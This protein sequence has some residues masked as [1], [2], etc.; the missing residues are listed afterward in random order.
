MLGVVATEA[1][2][3]SPPTV[4]SY[5]ARRA[6]VLVGRSTV[7]LRAQP[8]LVLLRTGSTTGIILNSYS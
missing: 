7:V 4:A 3:R 6:V 5:V 1:P 2:P 8:L